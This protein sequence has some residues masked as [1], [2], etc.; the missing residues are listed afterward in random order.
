MGLNW[1][2]KTEGHLICAIYKKNIHKKTYVSVRWNISCFNIHDHK[3]AIKIYILKGFVIKCDYDVTPLLF[4]DH[5]HSDIL[6]I[7]SKNN[8]LNLNRLFTS[9]C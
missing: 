7:N 4:H 9:L 2:M 5:F 8:I 3:P 6:K 1:Q